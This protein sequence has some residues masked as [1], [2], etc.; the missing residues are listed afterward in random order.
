LK[1]LLSARQ[2]A[3]RVGIHH[4][5][6]LTLARMGKVPCYRFGKRVTFDEEEVLKAAHDLGG[7]GER[8]DHGDLNL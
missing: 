5:H 2:L 1:H 6:L 7:N 8:K 4:T 3:P